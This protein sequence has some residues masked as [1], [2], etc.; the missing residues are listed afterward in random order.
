MPRLPSRDDLDS[1]DCY[2]MKSPSLVAAIGDANQLKKTKL[3]KKNIRYL[4]NFLHA[5]TDPNSLDLRHNIPLR[6]PSGLTLA[7]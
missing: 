5:L 4:I 1:V 3:S 2:V 7:E 6:V